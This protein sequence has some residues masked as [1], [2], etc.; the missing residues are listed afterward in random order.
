MFWVSD[1]TSFWV[2]D[3]PHRIFE[4]LTVGPGSRFSLPLLRGAGRP[5]TE[6]L[7]VQLLE[8]GKDLSV[9]PCV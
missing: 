3:K 2:S 9:S 1:L 7:L 6:A 8:E 5:K 4:T